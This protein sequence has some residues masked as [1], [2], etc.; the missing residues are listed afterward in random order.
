MYYFRI[1]LLLFF[2]V[3]K[4]YSQDDIVSRNL[5]ILTNNTFNGRESGTV[6]DRLFF[7]LLKKNFP[8]KKF[9]KQEVHYLKQEKVSVKTYNYYTYIN[10]KKD[11]TILFISHYDH[12]GN[13]KNGTSNE[14]INKDCVLSGADDNAS[15]VC[16]NFLLF[17]S[18]GRLHNQKYNYVFLFSS[19]H[20]DGL[21]GSKCFFENY[22]KQH[23][24]YV[25]NFDMVGRMDKSNT[26]RIETNGPLS[27]FKSDSLSLVLENIYS[28][29]EHTIF[30]K[31]KINSVFITTGHHSDYHRCSDT[32]EKININGIYKIASLVFEIVE[33]I[34]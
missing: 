14:I 5:K 18:I 28:S 10:N 25:F 15:G 19:G 3:N 22:K 31:N 17:D 34:F 2:I 13:S 11:S 32:Y 27:N 33:N 30:V 9:I 1:T 20:E 4:L 23:I 26:I 29:G 6:S 24:Q 7:D 21:Y 12:L 8:S 16:L